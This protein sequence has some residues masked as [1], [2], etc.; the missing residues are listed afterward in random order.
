MLRSISLRKQTSQYILTAQR[1]ELVSNKL[2][3]RGSFPGDK[4]G[5]KIFI[6]PSGENKTHKSA[7]CKRTD[8]AAFL[9]PSASHDRHGNWWPVAVEPRETKW[10]SGVVGLGLNDGPRLP[11]LNSTTR[12]LISSTIRRREQQEEEPEV[13]WLAIGSRSALDWLSYRVLSAC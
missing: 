8:I 4:V 3:D 6:T 1:T 11:R 2:N 13:V 12:S 10:G 7:D 5:V 9:F